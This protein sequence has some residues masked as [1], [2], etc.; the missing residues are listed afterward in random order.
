MLSGEREAAIGII[1]K[2]IPAPYSSIIEWNDAP[3]R[4][5]AEVQDLLDRAIDSCEDVLFGC[6]YHGMKA[7][8]GIRHRRAVGEAL[9]MAHDNQ[10]FDMWHGDAFV[11]VHIHQDEGPAMLYF[12][13]VVTQRNSEYPMT[14][15]TQR[16][17]GRGIM[18][19]P[20]PELAG[21]SGR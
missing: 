10:D 20:A 15:D 18:L 6:D 19:H 9:A 8:I 1:N 21:R 5:H 17:L 16:L 7:A 12:Y 3:V 2:F 4:T 11:D 14:T 13:P